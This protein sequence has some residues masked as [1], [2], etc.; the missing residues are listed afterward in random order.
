MNVDRDRVPEALQLSTH[1][2]LSVGLDSC[3]LRFQSFLLVAKAIGKWL[4]QTGV[5]VLYV[6][7]GSPWQNGHTESF[8]S[9]L[10][11]EFLKVEEFTSVRHAVKMTKEFQ[12][13]YNEVRTQSA[14]E[15]QTLNEFAGI[16]PSIQARQMGLEDN[17][18]GRLFTTF[19]RSRLI[20]TVPNLGS[21]PARQQVM[22]TGEP[23]IRPIGALNHER[24]PA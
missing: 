14:L 21:S 7:S 18:F 9:K 1:A 11:D 5:S 20:T 6:V 15:Y 3:E 22:A 4:N 2:L 16:R 23:T 24:R 12:C 10:R 19:V 17:L 8:N 13:Q